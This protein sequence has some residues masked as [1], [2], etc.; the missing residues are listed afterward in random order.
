MGIRAERVAAEVRELSERYRLAEVLFQDEDFFADAERV[1][2]TASGL[3]GHALRWQAR[4]RPQDVVEAGPERLR[5]LAQSGCRRLR[6]L[7][8]AQG[9]PPREML[10][11][12]GAR[13][14]AAGLAARFVFEVAEPD[15]RFDG[16]KCAVSA[17]RDLCALDGRFETPIRRVQDPCPG[18]ADSLEG[19]AARAG[20][21]WSDPRA[22]RRRARATFFF[23]EAQRAPGHRLGQHLMRLVA[24]VRVRLGFFALDLD[25]L[26]VE[27][28]AALRTGRARRS[29]GGD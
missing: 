22:E 26:A 27:A 7:V 28:A 15:G 29:P 6:F 11:E 17:A 25:R 16:L 9:T 2:A 10:L 20:S 12:A 1:D 3:V 19:W 21:P 5:L 4:A 14:H 13:L 24:L 23:G 8:R 18:E